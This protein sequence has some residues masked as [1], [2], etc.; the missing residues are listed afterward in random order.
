MPRLSLFLLGPPQLMR[1]GEV[2]E[3]QRRKVKALLIFLAVT[4]EPYQREKLATMLW[5]DNSQKQAHGSLRSNL[6]EL[7]SIL[8]PDW[9]DTD[10][11]M[12]G[13][14]PTADLWLDINQFHQH[15]AECQSHDHS[16]EKV[17]PTCI[18]PLTEAV[19]LYRDDFLA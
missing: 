9:L 1:M 15:L 6:S 5:P 3:I 7:N 18:T 11:E 8:E 19:A 2:V 4:R 16:P 12:I 10:R 14:A 17:C 13:L